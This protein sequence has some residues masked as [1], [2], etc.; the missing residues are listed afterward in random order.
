MRNGRGDGIPVDV[1]PREEVTLEGVGVQVDDPRHE[2]V[3]VEVLPDAA[4]SP[5]DGGDHPIADQ[6]GSD[7][8]FI[9]RDDARVAK[10]LFQNRLLLL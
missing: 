7:E 5:V 1:R 10:R 3:A 8:V 9:A 6:H 4:W 2:H